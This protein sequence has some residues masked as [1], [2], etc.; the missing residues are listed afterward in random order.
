MLPYTIQVV[1]VAMVHEDAWSFGVDFHQPCLVFTWLNGSGQGLA[2][3]GYPMQI[4]TM[5]YITIIDQGEAYQFSFIESKY[6]TWDCSIERHCV[7]IDTP[8]MQLIVWRNFCYGVIIC[9]QSNISNGYI[10]GAIFILNSSD[11]GQRNW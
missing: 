6:R 7:E 3:S 1:C 10:E 11:F 5:H 2:W 9:N 4:E 8:R